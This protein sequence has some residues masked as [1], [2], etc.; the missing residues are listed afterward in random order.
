MIAAASAAVL[1]PVMFLPWYGVKGVSGSVD[2]WEAFCWLDPY[3]FLTIIVALGLAVL[4]MT[5]RTVALPLSASLLV[6]GMGALAV[7]LVLYRIID[8]PG[9]GT[10]FGVEIEVTRKIGLYL[11]FLASGGIAFGGFMSMRDEG[12]SFG[13]A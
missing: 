2:A 6:T 5:Q 12:A 9:G 8:T 1:F 10:F 7:L 13:S 11:G 4:T 3:L